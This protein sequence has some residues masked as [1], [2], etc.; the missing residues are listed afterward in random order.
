LTQFRWEVSPCIAGNDPTV[1]H[2]YCEGIACRNGWD[3][4]I[5][6]VGLVHV[7]LVC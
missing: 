4:Q 1:D 7:E 6:G 3:L 5:S 2:R